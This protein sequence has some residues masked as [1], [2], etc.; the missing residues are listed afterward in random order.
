MNYLALDTEGSGLFDFTKPA[1]APGQPRLA[2]IG[3]ILADETLAETERHGF[4]IRPDG[5]FF[6]N[7]SEAAQVN[8]LTHERLMD[9]GISVK[10][11]LRLYG[12]ALDSRRIVVGHNVLHDLKMM[13]AEMRLVGYPDRFMETRYICTMQGSRQAV[14]ART[15]DGKKKAPRL[16]EA[17]AFFNIPLEEKGAH[18][19]IGGAE[20]AL[21]ILR[22][23]HAR[24]EMPA[25]KDPYDKGP[26]K[27]AP[28]PRA[29][30]PLF[31]D[32]P[33]SE[34]GIPNFIGGA[35]ADDK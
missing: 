7:H 30:A 23:L 35:S 26:K 33:D 27:P 11:A 28:K 22:R 17:C 3:M 18:T 8:G 1:D 16:E 6:D 12:D 20:R 10:E 9:E 15:A 2:A 13:R 4:L 19:G 31:D 29:R 34:Q 25:F 24:G 32:R 21:E 14:D 5:W